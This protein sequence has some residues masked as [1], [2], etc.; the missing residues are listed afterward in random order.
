ML[1][2]GTHTRHYRGEI[3]ETQS[4]S[5]PQKHLTS[6]LEKLGKN[7]HHSSVCVSVSVFVLHISLKLPLHQAEADLEVDQR[8]CRKLTKN[9]VDSWSGQSP[10]SNFEMSFGSVAFLGLVLSLSLSI[11][12]ATPVVYSD[13]QGQDR[14]KLIFISLLFFKLAFQN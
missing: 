9:M 12:L 8:K 3:L 2:T 7:F 14:G 10:V 11:C 4:P 13:V 1:R 6:T 5:V